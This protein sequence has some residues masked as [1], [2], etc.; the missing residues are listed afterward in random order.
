MSNTEEHAGIVCWWES[1][2]FP[3]RHRTF[4]AQGKKLKSKIH[5]DSTGR[6]SS[7]ENNRKCLLQNIVW[8]LE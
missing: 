2:N 7:V 6:E 1:P 5:L 4:A 8:H 3:D